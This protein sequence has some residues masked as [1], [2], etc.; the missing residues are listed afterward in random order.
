MYMKNNSSEESSFANSSTIS[1]STAT[2][3]V[4]N[5]NQ[6]A[7][8]GWLAYEEN[9]Y[10]HKLQLVE[11]KKMLKTRVIPNDKNGFGA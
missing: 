4:K 10:K 2:T 3:S 9:F 8:T 6:E 5:N 1:T 7:K 11:I